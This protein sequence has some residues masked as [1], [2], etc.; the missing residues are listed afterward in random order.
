MTV[1][2]GEVFRGDPPIMK[3]HRPMIPIYKA[4]RISQ[5]YSDQYRSLKKAVYER[6]RSRPSFQQGVDSALIELAARLF[7]DWLLV[8]EALSSQEA[9]NAVW[10]HADALAKI[11]SM[12]LATLEELHVTPKMREKIT[13]EI[14]QD[15][16]VTTKLKK[17]MGAQ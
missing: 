2:G 15:D 17:L 14:V 6:L 16:Q 12:L 9:K 13:Q 10:K 1:V 4:K 7:A 5:R 3:E 11:H 8:E